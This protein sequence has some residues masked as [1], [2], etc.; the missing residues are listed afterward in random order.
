[1]WL[2]GSCADITEGMCG[3]WNANPA[4]DI[5]TGDVNALMEEFKEYDEH[6]P[7]PPKPPDQCQITGEGAREE[8]LDICSPLTGILF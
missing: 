2:H 7:S 4:D 8:A 6:C 1:M 5:G 3:N